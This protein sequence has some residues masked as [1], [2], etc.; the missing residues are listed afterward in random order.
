M[1][2]GEQAELPA[3]PEGLRAGPGSAQGPQKVRVSEL[4]PG[5]EAEGVYLVREKRLIRYR[6][7]SRGNYLSLLLAD[8]TGQVQARVWE[9]A[10]K[11]SGMFEEGDCVRVRALVEVYQ[12]TQ[13]LAVR[14][15]ALAEEH[16]VDEQVYPELPRSQRA[17]EEMLA[18]HGGAIASIGNR[19]LRRL[20]D[21]IFGDK[22]IMD[23]YQRCPGAV[24]VHHAYLGGL[25]EHTLEVVKLCRAVC[26]IYPAL[27]RDLLIAG[28]LVHDIGKT[29]ELSYDITFDYTDAGKLLGH[30]PLGIQ[31]VK[32]KMDALK[33]FPQELGMRL[34]HLILSHH[35]EDSRYSP[36]RPMTA[37]A[38]ALHYAENL[39][40]Q[41]NRFVGVIEKAKAE[42]KTWTEW[43]ELLH[44]SLYAGPGEVD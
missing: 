3:P 38:C 19:E 23:R 25:L 16:E 27:D 43:Q 22:E 30:I 14:A 18:E 28:T 12:G 24:K 44:R 41:V 11:A 31:M 2:R 35:G 33:D 5:V 9:E 26:E 40:A 15:I 17:V 21:A 36:Q 39:D 4:K 13:Q 37:E 8:R 29:L 32:D 6:D 34:L 10:E 20:L 42:G 1:P 7:P